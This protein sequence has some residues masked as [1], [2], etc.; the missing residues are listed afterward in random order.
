MHDTLA[1]I[2]ANAVLLEPENSVHSLASRVITNWRQSYLVWFLCLFV[3]R[4]HGAER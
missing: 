2:V 1:I 3:V 4:E